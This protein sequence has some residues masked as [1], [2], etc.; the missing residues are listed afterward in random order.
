M[1][2]STEE[3]IEKAL[4]ILKKKCGNDGLFRKLKEKKAFEKP[5]DKKRRK[6]KESLRKKLMDERRKAKRQKGKKVAWAR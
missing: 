3:G 4:S 5:G 2:G 1:D 6:I